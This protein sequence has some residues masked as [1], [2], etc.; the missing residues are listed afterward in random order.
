MAE[1]LL[2]T[3]P[4]DKATGKLLTTTYTDQDVLN[5]LDVIFKIY[6]SLPSR[7]TVDDGNINKAMTLV[8][9]VVAARRARGV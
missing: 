3:G 8:K 5:Q 1:Q 2:D 9:N 6:E 7:T 4:F